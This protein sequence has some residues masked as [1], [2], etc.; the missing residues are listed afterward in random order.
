LKIR[1]VEIEMERKELRE[2]EKGELYFEK[3]ERLLILKNIAFL[4]L[5]F[6]FKDISIL[7]INSFK[8]D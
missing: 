5:P 2:L 4:S 6:Y 8:S 3:N 7:K 1:N